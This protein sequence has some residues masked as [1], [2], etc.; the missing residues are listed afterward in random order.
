MK[1]IIIFIIFTFTLIMNMSIVLFWN[2]EIDN[3]KDDEIQSTVVFGNTRSLCKVDGVIL[4]E[5]LDNSQS[6]E[7]DSILSPLST[8]EIESI[9]EELNT[10]SEDEIIKAF[11]KLKRRLPE[12]EYKRIEEI[13]SPFIDIEELDS[14][15]KNKYV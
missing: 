12:K 10:C 7:L 8:F 6:N 1:K 13:L 11:K 4:L 2:P 9:K 15:L 5:E 3:K 14:I